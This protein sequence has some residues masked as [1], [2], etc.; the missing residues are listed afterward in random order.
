MLC[1][2]LDIYGMGSI[3]I[4]LYGLLEREKKLRLDL[5]KSEIK[6]SRLSQGLG[7]CSKEFLTLI[8]RLFLT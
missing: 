4:E 1:L 5:L 6:F 3:N 7:W 8:L 2:R